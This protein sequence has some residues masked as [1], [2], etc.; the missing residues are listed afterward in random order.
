MIADKIKDDLRRELNYILYNLTPIGF[1]MD[2]KVE[3][4]MRA[5]AQVSCQVPFSML[6]HPTSTASTQEIIITLQG[7]IMIHNIVQYGIVQETKLLV[8]NSDSY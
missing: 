2:L 8:S 5:W 1:L 7:C 3:E 6:L 4:V